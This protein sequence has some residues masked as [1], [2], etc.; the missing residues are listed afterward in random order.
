M[1]D[2]IIIAEAKTFLAKLALDREYH[3]ADLKR[4]L[5]LIEHG[6][7]VSGSDAGPEEIA[8]LR[9][10]VGLA[11]T[12]AGHVEMDSADPVGMMQKIIAHVESV[13]RAFINSIGCASGLSVEEAHAKH[14]FSAERA[15]H[16]IALEHWKRLT[17][18]QEETK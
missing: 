18:P 17:A 9:M 1:S 5:A 11:T 3:D 16:A 14:L 8:Q 7:T 12:M 10:A 15:R 2:K 13:R 6:S 4:V